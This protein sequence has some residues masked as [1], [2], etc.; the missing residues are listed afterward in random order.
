MNHMRHKFQ[1]LNNEFGYIEKRYFG[2]GGGSAQSVS[3][4]EQDAL[5]RN[6][7]P[8]VKR[9]SRQALRSRPLYDVPTYDVPGA[10]SMM[11]TSDW[12]SNLSPEVMQGVW[13]P[14]QDA[15]KQLQE[16]LGASGM[17]GSAI[18][19]ISGTA[20]SGLGKFWEQAG[21][22]VGQQAWGMV[23]PAL[24]AEWQGNLGRNQW[25]A[26]AELQAM[27]AP[28]SAVG[29]TPSAL[30]DVAYTPESQFNFGNAALGYG[31]GVAGSAGILSAMGI[32]GN[33][34]T[35][36]LAIGAGLLA[37]KS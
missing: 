34:W 5:I 28:Y 36:P 2:G 32:A 4:P 11:P 29:L 18:G 24:S 3:S 25:T 8:M 10:E 35:A 6:I 31:G 26:G 22:N 21:R 16:Q 20:A 27:Q 9:M 13:A 30:P 23:Q 37:G 19:G 1:Q 12:Y 15:S 33:P 7:I 17:G 14:Y